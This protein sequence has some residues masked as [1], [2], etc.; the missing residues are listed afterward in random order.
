MRQY[1]SILIMGI[2]IT[3]SAMG[4]I[5]NTDESVDVPFLWGH[6]WPAGARPLGMGGA[7]SAVAD[8][9]SAIVYNP[10]GLARIKHTQVHA[11][12]SQMSY[13]SEVNSLN[14]V[15]EETT[16]YTKL[17]D[18]GLSIPIPTYRGSLTFGFGYHRIRQLDT[19]IMLSR[20][21]RQISQYDTVTVDYNNY[22]EGSLTNTSFGGSMEV[23]PDLFMGLSLNI[24]GGRREY[25]NQTMFLDR[26]DIYYWSHFDS[27][28]NSITDFSGL[29]FTLGMIYQIKNLGSFSVVIK[30]PVTLK[31]KEN[32]DYAD[33]RY[34]EYYP[35]EDA[36]DKPVPE[37]VDEGYSEYKIRSPWILR[38]GG[39]LS[40]GPVTLAGDVEFIDYSQFKYVTDTPYEDTDKTSANIIIRQKLRNIKNIYTGGEITIPGM[41]LKL[42]G[43]YTI[44]ENPVRDTIK[45]KRTVWSAG[46]GYTFSEQFSI[47]A[48]YAKTSWNGIPRNNLIDEE[49]LNASKI[50][51]TLSYY[52]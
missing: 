44:L 9:Q 29:N 41:P 21:A 14:T 45:D 18:L 37:A 47:D 13:T 6:A 51:V 7:Y 48:A 8:G 34:Y 31:A 5:G 19:A 26:D 35:E 28:D 50:L 2:L 33:I 30:T 23:A 17:N 36:Y 52:L 46:F 40:K 42:R 22:T 43:G 3:G 27:T 12:L 10:A 25:N 39:S 11:S 1:L 49:K 4:Q 16:T 15:S 24:W 38:M 32:W 20:F